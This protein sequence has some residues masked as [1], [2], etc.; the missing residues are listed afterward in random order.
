MNTVYDN[1]L[2]FAS[3]L[4]NYLDEDQKER[5]LHGIK[6]F[7]LELD[8]FD[9]DDVK[10]KIANRELTRFRLMPAKTFVDYF[11]YYTEKSEIIQ[12]RRESLLL[13]L[14]R[15]SED[16]CISVSVK[17][18]KITKFY[19]LASALA[20]DSRYASWIDDTAHD[21]RID[22]S[23]ACGQSNEIS[24]ELATLIKMRFDVSGGY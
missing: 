18:M 21:I 3:P 19:D 2:S 11:D 6:V 17:A 13:A 12:I 1:F 4:I 14:N 8:L 10:K 5:V 23:F 20:A 15:V 22:L 16:R 7:L 24:E 9:K